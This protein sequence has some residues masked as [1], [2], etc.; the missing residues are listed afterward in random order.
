MEQNPSGASGKKGCD[1]DTR[2]IVLHDSLTAG[3]SESCDQAAKN[4]NET[5]TG[6]EFL[7]VSLPN[8]AG[9]AKQCEEKVVSGGKAKN[10]GCGQRSPPDEHSPSK[11][12]EQS[13]VA[14]KSDHGNLRARHQ[15]RKENQRQKTKAAPEDCRRSQRFI[16]AQFRHG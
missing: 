8:R 9:N 5:G 11:K 7:N 3:A 6:N 4:H 16:P 1:P 10:D 15:H 12:D 14:A 2:A 13:V